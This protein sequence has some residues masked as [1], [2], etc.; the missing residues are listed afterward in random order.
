MSHYNTHCN[1][2]CNA[3]CNTADRPWHLRLHMNQSYHTHKWVMSR[4]QMCHVSHTPDSKDAGCITES[5]HI[6]VS[7]VTYEWVMSPMNESCPIRM[8]HVTHA[9]VACLAHTKQQRRWVYEWFIPRMNV[10]CHIWM[11]HVTHINRLWHVTATECN[12][13]L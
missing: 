2:H 3:Q 13:T 9:N 5:C 4:T 10:W 6:G 11:S 1:A 7:H 8:S 12:A